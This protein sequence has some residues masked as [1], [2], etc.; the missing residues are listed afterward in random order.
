MGEWENNGEKILVTMIGA[1]NPRDTEYAFFES[2][3]DEN[4]EIGYRK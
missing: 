3:T 1:S 4:H 2:C